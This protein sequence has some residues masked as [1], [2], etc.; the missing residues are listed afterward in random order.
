MQSNVKGNGSGE[1]IMSEETIM[2]VHGSDMNLEISDRR[3]D[4]FRSCHVRNPFSTLSGVG[5]HPSLP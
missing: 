5:N 3:N 4:V 1:Y 2:F